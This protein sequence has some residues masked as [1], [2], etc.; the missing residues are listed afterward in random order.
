MTK[1][2]KSAVIKALEE[3][4]AELGEDYVYPEAVAGVGCV[5][6]KNGQASCIAGR[7]IAKI[8][9]EKIE[10]IEE[11]EQKWGSWGASDFDGQTQLAEG[12]EG[13]VINAPKLDATPAALEALGA[14]QWS[15]DRRATYGQALKAAKEARA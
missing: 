7:V 8:D 1:F 14:A 12:D 3:I 9:P 10:Q 11:L 2:T 6:V 13:E 5:Y 4:V 15:Q